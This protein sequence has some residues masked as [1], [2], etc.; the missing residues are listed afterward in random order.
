MG[1]VLYA[2]QHDDKIKDDSI[3]AGW[4]D[5]S[6]WCLFQMIKETSVGFWRVLSIKHK[7]SHGRFAPGA[8][9]QGIEH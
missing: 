4:L 3:L 8:L 6:P 9:E 7:S 2:E 1:W 5:A